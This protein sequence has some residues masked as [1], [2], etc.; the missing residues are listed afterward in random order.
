MLEDEKK[1]SNFM[2]KE[3]LCLIE[4]R[5][6][7]T[8]YTKLEEILLKIKKIIIKEEILNKIY[9]KFI[10][11]FFDNY[12][13]TEK[14][15]FFVLAFF[16]MVNSNIISI[17]KLFIEKIF[18][19]NK[20]ISVA[21]VQIIKLVYIK[22]KNEENFQLPSLLQ[23]I[24]YCFKLPDLLTNYFQGSFINYSQYYEALF[25][26]LL[27]N[28]DVFA[29]NEILSKISN[30][31]LYN[32]LY[33]TFAH[34]DF[35]EEMIQNYLNNISKNDFL[36][37]KFYHHFFQFSCSG[38]KEFQKFQQIYYK[39]EDF[40]SFQKLDQIFRKNPYFISLI[41]S[42][43]NVNLQKKF[44][45]N[46]LI[47]LKNKNQ[48]IIEEI[49]NYDF[50]LVFFSF[51]Y[52]LETIKDLEVVNI[53]DGLMKIMLLVMDIVSNRNKKG[54]I[55]LFMGYLKKKIYIF[56]N[57]SKKNKEPEEE[58]KEDEYMYFDENQKNLLNFE[59]N[60][61][62]FEKNNFYFCATDIENSFKKQFYHLILKEK[63]NFAKT[64]K[65]NTKIHNDKNN[66]SNRKNKTIYKS[67]KFQKKYGVFNQNN[68]QKLLLAPQENEV[69]DDIII[70]SNNSNSIFKMSLVENDDYSDLKKIDSPQ[71]IKDCILGLNSQYKERQ[72]LSLK[73]LPSLIDSQPLDLEL[74]LTELTNCILRL[75]NSFDIDNFDELVEEIL[76][77]L[78]KFSPDKLTKILCER[79]FSE[80]NCGLKSKFVILT[81]INKAVE[82][83]S[84]YYQ[85]NN[86]PKVNLFHPY[87]INVIFP[88]LNYLQK[89]KLEF[90]ITYDNFDLLLAKFI[91]II[92]NIIKVSENHPLVNK[93][94]F[95]TFELFQAIIKMLSNKIKSHTLIES[96]N[97]YV[98]SSL[99]FYKT[100][101]ISVYPEY[102]G[103]LQI[104]IKYLN[105]L[106]S[107]T[108][109]NED[110]RLRILATLNKY[111]LQSQKFKSTY[112]N[113]PDFC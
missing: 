59:K 34:N 66:M 111:I 76:V 47:L 1:S 81:V 43:K 56:L 95:E 70:P 24:N 15:V 37:D 88:L 92:S 63:T 60:K 101:F 84:E 18:I 38:E 3:L 33:S 108:Q 69:M 9:E 31:K 48:Y 27:Q 53:F 2:I 105:D 107:D 58:K 61:Q 29:L 94:L 12:N 64:I 67:I 87:F 113:I 106:L 109:L 44:L 10:N 20:K 52:L 16:M 82:E 26:Q 49:E 57:S 100:S 93:A 96:L 85:S 65:D 36:K 11:T 55:Q 21:E 23:F 98:N 104:E 103:K 74:S 83:I 35:S 99:N 22:K 77:K 62:N 14:N 89:Q 46:S 30:L 25:L 73:S 79:F 41:L 8:I 13:I 42:V 110:L 51:Y 68:N 78:V 28:E 7:F 75:D 97:F 90:L 80:N 45:N 5:D 50:Y 112:F 4:E 102:L 54:I 91:F 32:H 19:D 40:R 6:Y 17:P 86:K 72:E 39:I 71:Y